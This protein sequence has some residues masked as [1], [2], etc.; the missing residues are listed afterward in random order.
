HPPDFGRGT[1]QSGVRLYNERLVLSLVRH[2]GALPKATISRLTGLS[3]PS[4]STIVKEL[5]RDGLLLRQA[6]QRGRIA[7]PS[8]PASLNPDGAFALGVKIGRRRSEMVIM[9]FVGAVRAEF[10]RT[11]VYPK[12]R[13]VLDFIAEGRQRLAKSL[14]DEG[15]VRIAGLG[16]ASPFELWN[17]E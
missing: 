10:H 4:V 2:H 9:D 15:R 3:P 5:E 12:P 8:V 6:P 13:A 7:Q 1:R 16:I 11:Y 14:S 17:W